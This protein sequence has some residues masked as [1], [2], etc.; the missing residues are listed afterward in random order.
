MRVAN[1][2]LEHPLACYYL[3]V[4]TTAINQCTSLAE[5]LLQTLPDTGTTA[6][7]IEMR[8]FRYDEVALFY[9]NSPHY[10]L[11]EKLI[12]YE[13]LG[14][15]PRYHAL[16]D[17]TLPMDEAVVNLLMRRANPL[18]SEPMHVYRPRVHPIWR[19]E[20]AYLPSVNG[21]SDAL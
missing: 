4:Q 9:A 20:C 11:R 18:E 3:A 14:G 13:I 10:G 21:A 6:G 8:L 17:T 15:T 12:V 7:I 19:T 1:E 16:V 5:Q 2:N